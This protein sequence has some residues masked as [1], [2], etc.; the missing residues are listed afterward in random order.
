MCSKKYIT[1]SRMAQTTDCNFARAATHHHT[2]SKFTRNNKLPKGPMSTIVQAYNQQFTGYG[3]TT[4]YNVA[5]KKF[6][7]VTRIVSNNN[8]RPAGAKEIFLGTFSPRSWSLLKEDE[9]KQHT[10]R[11]CEVCRHKYASIPFPSDKRKQPPLTPTIT[12]T[13]DDMSSH[14]KFGTRLLDES[15]KLTKVFYQKSV[16]DVMQETPKS[17][18]VRKPTSREKKTEKRKS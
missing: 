4:T 2:K 9:K 18:L 13:P 1:T 7:P 6:L 5:A 12:F 11:G 14:E 8:W 16:Q 3:L 17:R 15:N 10:L